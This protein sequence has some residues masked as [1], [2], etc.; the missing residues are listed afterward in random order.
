VRSPPQEGVQ[1]QLCRR[2]RRHIRREE[3]SR[4]G[5]SGGREYC[6]SRDWCGM[7]CRERQRCHGSKRRLRRDGRRIDN[8]C[9]VLSR[10]GRI[11]NL[12]GELGH[13]RSGWLYRR[14]PRRRRQIIGGCPRRPGC[15]PEGSQA[16]EQD[17]HRYYAPKLNDRC[18]PISPDRL[19]FV[20]LEA[21]T[22]RRASLP[23]DV[24]AVK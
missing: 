3:R 18:P 2:W 10:H 8:G 12:G 6:R 4:R 21:E 23:A 20:R 24:G 22:V 7:W 16:S 17:K 19:Q 9:G 1:S 13:G 14:E 15:K 5:G 11:Q